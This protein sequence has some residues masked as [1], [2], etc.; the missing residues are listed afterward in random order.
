MRSLLILLIAL[1]SGMSGLAFGASASLEA[2]ARHAVEQELLPRLTTGADSLAL[3]W[4]LPPLG[5]QGREDGL[6]IETMSSQVRERGTSVVRLRIHRDGVTRKKLTLPVRVRR[7]RQLPVAVRDLAHGRVL[8]PGDLSLRLVEVTDMRDTD[9]PGLDEALGQQL[10][11]Y[12]AAGRT[13]HGRM[14]RPLPD[15]RRGD[16]LTVIVSSGGIRIEAP[17][18]AMEEARKGE[19]L[20]VRLDETGKRLRARLVSARRAMVEAGG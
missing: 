17:G 1:L 18:R 11:R 15:V 2:Q 3:E 9:L 12:L 6:E 19:R 7:W 10:V 5:P 8:E 20:L 13:V 16:A 4:K 14:I